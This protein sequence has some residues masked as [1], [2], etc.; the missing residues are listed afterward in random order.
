MRTLK[1]EMLSICFYPLLPVFAKNIYVQKR[2]PF[3]VTLEYAIFT[4]PH[5]CHTN[6][7]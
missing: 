5:F 4:H 2:L 7:A 3:V 1:T 6:L